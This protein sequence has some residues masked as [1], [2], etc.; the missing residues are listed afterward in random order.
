M[1]KLLLSTCDT[2]LSILT[3]ATY[4]KTP[5]LLYNFAWEKMKKSLFTPDREPMTN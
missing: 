2:K 1:Y 5:L 4:A 3:M